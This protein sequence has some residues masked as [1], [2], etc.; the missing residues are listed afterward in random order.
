M[1]NND[2]NWFLKLIFEKPLEWSGETRQDQ[3]AA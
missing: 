3:I 2:L 1:S